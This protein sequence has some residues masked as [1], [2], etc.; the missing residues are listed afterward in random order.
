MQLQPLDRLVDCFAL[1]M[2]GEPDEIE[3][4]GRDRLDCGA[5]G[6][7]MSGGEEFAGIERGAQA[8]LAGTAHHAGEIGRGGGEDQHRLADQRAIDLGRAVAVGFP[9]ELGGSGDEPARE[10]AGD[11]EL[12][13]DGELLVDDDGNLGVEAHDRHDRERPAGG[14]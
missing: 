3:R 6:F 14:S 13:P 2:E 12:L 7:V 4:V 5:V 9:T 10:E 8:R 11:V 1:A